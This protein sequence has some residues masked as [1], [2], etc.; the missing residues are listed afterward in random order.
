MFLTSI[1]LVCPAE[2]NSCNSSSEFYKFRNKV[3]HKIAA[4]SNIVAILAINQKYCCI[5][6]HSIHLIYAESFYSGNTT[7]YYIKPFMSSSG[8]NIFNRSL[9][10]TCKYRNVVLISLCPNNFC[11][12]TTSVPLSSRCVAKLLKQLFIFCIENRIFFCLIEKINR[13]F[14]KSC[15]DLI[16][17]NFLCDLNSRHLLRSTAFLK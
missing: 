1:V 2:R 3:S 9:L 8:L 6:F 16:Q 14:L 12:S 15:I 13:I 7:S 17:K 10:V 11:I 5:D 4:N